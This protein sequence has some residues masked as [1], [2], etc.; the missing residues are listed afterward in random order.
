MNEIS[1]ST[2]PLKQLLDKIETP[3]GPVAFVPDPVLGA[4][5][6]ARRLLQAPPI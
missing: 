6:T 5:A 3:L 4:V 2:S 1:A